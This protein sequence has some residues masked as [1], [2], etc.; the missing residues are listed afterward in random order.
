[1]SKLV[2]SLKPYISVLLLQ[3]RRSSNLSNKKLFDW[4]KSELNFNTPPGRYSIM[5]EN[6]INHLVLVGVGGEFGVV[7][8]TDSSKTALLSSA[9]SSSN[10]FKQIDAGFLNAA[11]AR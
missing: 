7:L 2:A 11:F 6:V 8:T 3:N 10:S 4:A 1:M 5:Q 9:L